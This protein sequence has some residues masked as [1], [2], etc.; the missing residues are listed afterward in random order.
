ML[1]LLIVA[2]DDEYRLV[3]RY[4]PEYQTVKTGIGAGNVIRVLSQIPHDTPVVN[5]GYVGSNN[6]PIGKVCRVSRSWR[7]RDDNF[8]FTDY[9]HGYELSAE[10]YPCYT[11]NEFVTSTDKTEPTL[12]DMELNYIVAFP[13]RHLGAIK[14]VSD[15]LSLET[16]EETIAKT[17]DELWGEVRRML[18]TILSENA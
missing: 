12:F 8:Q 6:L 4:F 10:G 2:S 16:Y 18:D 17:E 1:P 15:H 7:V 9:R 13:L 14:I 11:G 3:T 5:I